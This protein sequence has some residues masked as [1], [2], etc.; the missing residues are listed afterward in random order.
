ME[1]DEFKRGNYNTHFIEKNQE[2]LMERQPC[3]DKCMDI[4][5]ISA[6]IHYKNK[7]ETVLPQSTAKLSLEGNAWRDFGR[8]KSFMKI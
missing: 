7:I 5:L 4:A 3:G 8:R 6:Y 1:N 2:F